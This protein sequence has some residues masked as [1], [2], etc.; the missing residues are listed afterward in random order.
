MF[1]FLTNLDRSY[2]RLFLYIKDIKNNNK[3]ISLTVC[4]YTLFSIVFRVTCYRDEYEKLQV[5]KRSEFTKNYLIL[6]D[7]FLCYINHHTY[8]IWILKEEFVFICLFLYT[9]VSKNNLNKLI[10]C[11]YTLLF[12]KYLKCQFC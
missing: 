11:V 5:P 12:L 1:Q 8:M 2:N 9:L 7:F 3:N 10:V 4:V 6:T